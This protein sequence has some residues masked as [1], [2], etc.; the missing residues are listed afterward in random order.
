M[1]CVYC[2]E[3]VPV[4]FAGSHLCNTPEI[5]AARTIIQ[6][7]YVDWRWSLRKNC[8]TYGDVVDSILDAM[9]KIREQVVHE[10]AKRDTLVQFDQVLHRVS[11]FM[12]NDPVDYDALFGHAA[13]E[14]DSAQPIAMAGLCCGC[15]RDI[16][17][18]EPKREFNGRP[19]CI[20]CFLKLP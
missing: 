10:L 9:K 1:K 12:A 14:V 20:D 13:V 2:G 6:A 19:I 15:G 5:V 3:E 7:V 8:H 4:T 17:E 11:S 18:H 16:P